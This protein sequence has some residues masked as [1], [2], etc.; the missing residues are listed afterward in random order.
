MK[1]LTVQNGV[2]FLAVTFLAGLTL[3][4][5][6][7]GQMSAPSQPPTLQPAQG[8]NQPAAQAGQQPATP[9]APPV[10]PKE[11]ADYKALY[12]T[13]ADA[14]DK[15]IQLG[16]AFLAAYPTSR[17]NEAVYNELLHAYYS[18]QDWDNFYSVGDKVVAIDPDDVDALAMVGWVIPHT[19]KSSDPDGQLKLAKAETYDKHVIDL[20]GTMV[21]PATLTDDQFAS[22]KSDALEQAHSGLGLVY[23]REQNAP[24]AVAQLQLATATSASPDPAD[25]YVLGIE[26]LQTNQAAQAA[27]AFQKCAALPGAL[28]DR[29]KQN[30]DQA[31]KQAAGK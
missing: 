31:K 6:S 26:L 24:E 19:F 16:T 4:T 14:A 18:K 7:H 9:A 28:Q 2:R 20:M 8:A 15:K 3:A 30:A 11:E 27:D 13:S 17:H 5:V 12:D 10:N 25:L 1:I 22:M 23:F 21:K 29:C